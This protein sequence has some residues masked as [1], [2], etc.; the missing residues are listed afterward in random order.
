MRTSHI[1]KTIQLHTHTHTHTHTHMYVSC[2][3]PWKSA[4]KYASMP[5]WLFWISHLR[6]SWCKRD[7]LTLLSKVGNKSLM[8]KVLSQH[9][10]LE[11]EEG[12]Y[13]H[14]E[15]IWGWEACINK[16]VT[17]LIYYPKLKLCLDYS[18][19]MYT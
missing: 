1:V 14:R 17:S 7:I 2:W 12:I 11:V 18:L 16:L 8:W 3:G 5:Y 4:S 6:K 19:I 15:G 13:H 9:L 10:Y